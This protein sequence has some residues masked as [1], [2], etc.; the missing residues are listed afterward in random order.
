[1]KPMRSRHLTW[2]SV[3]LARLLAVSALAAT[4]ACGS[5]STGPSN[6]PKGTFKGT[7]VG[8]D[9]SG[10]LTIS[11]SNSVA[12]RSATTSTFSFVQVAQA[13]TGVV[14]VTGTL[15]LTG[16][17]VIQLT[18]T[19]NASGNPQLLLAGSGYGLAGNY[20]ATNGVFSGTSTFPDG[21]TGLWTVSANASEVNVFCGTY[22]STQGNGGGTW[23][24]VLDSNNNLTGVATAAG[25]L[26]GTLTPG[27]NSLSVT[28]TGGTAS[29]T[30]NPSTGAGSG[31]YDAP[32]IGQ[33]DS[34]TWVA[35]TG[36]C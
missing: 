19:Y 4:A 10:V 26:Q 27:S 20:S 12:S 16:G 7:L 31:T 15:S 33:G 14:P 30:L 24:L 29:G 36:T 21:K 32:N 11:L 13:A 22:T 8:E 28:Y 17:S 18:G 5:S 2:R 25:Q 9:G 3:S 34:G 23:N 1:M 6:G 35:T